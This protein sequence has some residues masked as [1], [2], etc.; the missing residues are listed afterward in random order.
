[1]FSWETTEKMSKVTH[2][3]AA[4]AKAGLKFEAHR[5]V[6]GYKVRLKHSCSWTPVCTRNLF[7]FIK[8]GYRNKV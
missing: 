2:G 3:F 5:T 8:T 7:S 6:N 4:F 1:M